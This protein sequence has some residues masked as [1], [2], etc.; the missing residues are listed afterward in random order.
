MG[1]PS[2]YANLDESIIHLIKFKSWTLVG[3]IGYTISDRDDIEQELAIH[4]VDRL[5]H[6]DPSRG[7]LSTFVQRVVDNKVASMIEARK[8][9]KLDFRSHAYSLDELMRNPD[10]EVFRRGDEIEE[11]DYLMRTGRQSRSGQELVELSADIERVVSALPENMH[12]LCVS[13]MTQNVTDISRETGLSRQK[14]YDS[15]RSLRTV[16]RAAGLDEYA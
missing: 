5:K 2:N 1:I 3:K 8:T 13:L 7:K 6:F 16:F 4:I 11:D 14:I 9:R 12:K 15:I 10:G